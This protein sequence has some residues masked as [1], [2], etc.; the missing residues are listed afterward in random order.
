MKAVHFCCVAPP[1]GGGMGLAAD[2]EVKLLRQRGSEAWLVA[3]KKSGIE[4]A[5]YV[6]RAPAKNFGN[7]AFIFGLEKFVEDADIVHLHYPFYGVAGRIA[8]LK[9]QGK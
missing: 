7:A 4:S 1:Q 6:I 5:E 8:K 3:P 9:R 2:W